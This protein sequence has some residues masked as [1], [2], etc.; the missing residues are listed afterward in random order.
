MS[1][2]IK[3]S[4]AER[5]GFVQR[6]A[7]HQARITRDRALLASALAVPIYV[8]FAAVN[9]GV[10]GALSMA[11]TNIVAT[12]FAF[13]AIVAIRQSTHASIGGHFFTLALA[14]QVFGETAFNG[15]LQAP[16]AALSLL[17]VPAAVFTAGAGAVRPWAIV[18]VCV[19]AGIFSLDLLGKLPPNELM[20]DA[21]AVDRI[22]SLAAGIFIS[23]ALV[24]QF[25]RQATR[26]IDK[27]VEER[28]RYRHRALHDSLTGLPNRSHFYE[29][30]EKSI[31]DARQN[32]SHRALIYFDIDRFKQ[33][34]DGLG[35]AI[36]D[37]LLI[38]FASRLRQCTR[39]EDLVARLAGDEFAMIT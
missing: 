35:H 26:A 24:I 32:M 28:T 34:N 2:A 1:N 11:A 36:G 18:T 17:I 19:L 15:G 33:I 37:A 10:H 3:Q 23:A 9:A 21:L 4:I 8:A 31:E 12:L 22:L 20:A 38:A 25:D 6:A 39:P 27:L 7:T 16:A 14:A 5:F 30:A 29:H 13:C